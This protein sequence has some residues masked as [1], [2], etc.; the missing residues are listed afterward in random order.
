MS[1]ITFLGS[2]TDA[3]DGNLSGD[4]LVWVSDGDGLLGNG[5]EFS[6]YLSGGVHTIMLTVTDSTGASCSAQIT[7][8]V[9]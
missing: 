8:I 9:Q 3:E 1:S 2:G 4:Q 6:T 7:I 5:E